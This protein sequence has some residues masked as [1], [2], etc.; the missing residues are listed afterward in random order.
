MDCK[1]AHKFVEK[2]SRYNGK[3]MST[4]LRT[5]LTQTDTHHKHDDARRLTPRIIE[6]A[7]DDDGDSS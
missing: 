2:V 1:T 7:L 4:S 5:R 3:E 6:Y